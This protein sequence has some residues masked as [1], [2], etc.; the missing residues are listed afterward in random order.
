M[1]KKQPLAIVIDKLYIK[2]KNSYKILKCMQAARKRIKLIGGGYKGTRQEYRDTVLKYWKKF[3]VRPARYWYTLYCDGEG[4]YDPRYLPDTVWYNDI[5][6]YFNNLLFRGAYIDKNNFDRQLPGVKMPETVIKNIGGYFY[7]ANSNPITREEAEKL[8]VNEENL[9]FKPSL[10][11]GGGRLIQFYESGSMPASTVG[12]Y[13]DGYKTNFIVQRFVK[14]HADL[15]RIHAKSLNTVRVVSLH[16]KGEVHILSTQLR[17]GSGDSKVDNYTAGGY[18]ANINPDGSLAATAANKKEGIAEKHS[19][20]IYF[21]D[22]VVPSYDKI[23]ETVKKQHLQVPY[24]N[25]IGWDF[26]V[27]EVGDPVFIEYNVKPEP[28]QVASGPAFGD[29][30]DAVLQDVYIDKTLQ[31]AFL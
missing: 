20:G 19:S 23:I 13:F 27:D 14:Q 30:T 29:L 8:C 2:S 9:I 22:I 16:F 5:F 17:M 1:L 11:G 7:D 28:N 21:K 12:E 15:A 26:A 3:G 25:L 18:A 10:A 31:D 4:K 6:P 24:F